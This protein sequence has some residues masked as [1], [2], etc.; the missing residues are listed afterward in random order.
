MLKIFF[1]TGSTARPPRRGKASRT[2]PDGQ[3]QSDPE[4]GTVS[5]F[6]LHVDLARVGF[7]DLLDDVQTHPRPFRESIGGSAPAKGLK[8]HSE[9]VLGNAR[10]LIG[11]RQHRLRILLLDPHEN[12]TR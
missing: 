8:E 9:V 4:C 1:C 3:R 10:A 7:D 11:D 6:A 12:A 5:E 2:S